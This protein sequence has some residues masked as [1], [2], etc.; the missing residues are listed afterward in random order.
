MSNANAVNWLATGSDEYNLAL[1]QYKGNFADAWRNQPRLYNTPYPILHRQG[2]VKGMKAYQFLQFA[3][4]PAPELYSP[5]DEP[6]GQDF[7]VEQGTITVDRPILVSK[8]IPRDRLAVGHFDVFGKLGIAHAREIGMELDRRLFNTSVLAARTAALSGTDTGLTVHNGGNRVTRT[9]GSIASSYPASP[10]GAANLR[11][12]LRKLARLM[13]EDAIP[14]EMRKLYLHVQMREVLTYDSG[15]VW[16]TPSNTIAVANSN[17]FNTEDYQGNDG[18]SINQRTI[19]TLEG[20]DILGFV[21][22][23]SGSGSLPDTNVT[24]G[25]TKFQGNFSVA[26][27]TGIPVA[28]A[29]TTAPDGGAAMSVGVWDEVQ[30]NVYYDEKLMGW[31]MK[32]YLHTGVGVMYPYCAGTVEVIT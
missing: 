29:L 10:V 26:S 1:I 8:F 19:A 18:N 2:A 4:I 3:Q 6:V 25:P 21:N 12:D 17:L 5:G 20:F 22:P 7:E 30:A 9:G 11:A 27:S 28:I 16:G 15:F 24:T 23:Q 13:D 32:S 14:V 31:W